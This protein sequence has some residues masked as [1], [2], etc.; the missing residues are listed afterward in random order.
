MASELHLGSWASPFAV[1]EAGL[2]QASSRW[3]YLA[4]LAALAFVVNLYASPAF[5]FEFFEKFRLGVATAGLCAFA[6]VMRRV[7]SGE[8]LRFGG[9][10]A[11]LL[12]TYAATVPLSL[13]WT[14]S[15]DRTL[16]ATVDTAKCLLI[17]VALANALDAP[18][19]LRMFLLAGALA[20]LAPSTGT[21]LRWAT[22]DGLVEGYRAAWRGN[23][24][25]PNRCAMGLVFFLPAT[26]MA[27]GQAKRPWLKALLAF[28]AVSN[29]AAIVLTHSRSGAVAMA[30]AL[31]LTFLRGRSKG[32]GLILA[33]VAVLGLIALAPRSFWQRSGT[34]A[35]YEQ[36]ASFYE[37]E[38]A[39]SMLK[40]IADQRPLTGVGAGGFIE[41]WDRFAPLSAQGRHLIAHNIFMEIQG[42]QGAIALLL[43]GAFSA[44]LLWRLWWAGG[45][46]ASGA[47]ARA[48]FA[49]LIAFLICELVNGYSRTFNLYAAF[50]A[51]I[52]AAAHARL[53]A[54]L[55]SE[56]P[57]T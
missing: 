54:R 24:A 28:A 35:S 19:R 8:R 2:A 42:E 31:A 46:G 50:G 12:F 18:G 20:T 40:E 27:V 7:T 39:W 36:D 14:I 33:G 47:E 1:R 21:I 37:R 3:S 41:A 13:A 48:L 45:G 17:Y 34:I 30:I 26:I 44:W 6:V 32:R 43:F 11:L 16:D 15:P 51:A 52:V 22:G 25:D 4:Y 38:R 57:L 9:P 5:W 49:G 56:E 55:A 53:R 10:P 29:V 23:Y